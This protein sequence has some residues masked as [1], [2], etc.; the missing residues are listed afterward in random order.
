MTKEQQIACDLIISEDAIRNYKTVLTSEEAAR[1]LNIK[2][3]T[4]YKLT[5]AGVIPFSKPNNK[6]IYFSRIGLDNW[7][8]SKSRIGK[9][10]RQ[11][12]AATYVAFNS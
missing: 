7:M 4:L 2:I 3:S 9:E 12:L 5:S 10:K 1:Y 6:K 8:L 11:I